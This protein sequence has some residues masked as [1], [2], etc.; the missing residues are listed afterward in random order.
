MRM[1][2]QELLVGEESHLASLTDGT[3]TIAG[4]VHAWPTIGL[5]RVQQDRIAECWLLPLDQDAF[6]RVWTRAE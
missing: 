3:A 6:D 5:Y 4:F 2:P 1:H